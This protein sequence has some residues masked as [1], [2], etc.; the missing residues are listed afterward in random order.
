[1]LT[2]ERAEELRRKHEQG[3]KSDW[4]YQ[5]YGLFS[6]PG[7]LHD[8]DPS[9]PEQE[10][11]H[12][13]RQDTNKLNVRTCAAKAGTTQDAY[14]ST[15]KH[16]DDRYNDYR[17]NKE[18]MRSKRMYSMHGKPFNHSGN[19]KPLDVKYSYSIQGDNRKPREKIGKNF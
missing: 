7:T 15:F 8:N 13:F 6:Y 14:F 12:I 5:R 10:K 17:P 19:T 4:H 11:R 1:M 2:A 9:F 18:M 16:D 3:E